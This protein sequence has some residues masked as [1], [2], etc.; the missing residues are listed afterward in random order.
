MIVTFLFKL[1]DDDNDSESKRLYY[2]GTASIFHQETPFQISVLVLQRA[3]C[4]LLR[5]RGLARSWYAFA[6]DGIHP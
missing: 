6:G 4:S 3:S 1:L 2:T 5:P